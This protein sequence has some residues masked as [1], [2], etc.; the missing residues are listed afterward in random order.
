MQ[1]L[2]EVCVHKPPRTGVYT[3]V[4][5]LVYI[6]PRRFVYTNAPRTITQT[7]KSDYT[8]LEICYTNVQGTFVLSLQG[9]LCTRA[10]DLLHK[11]SRTICVIAPRRFVYKSSRFVTQTFLENVC[12]IATRRFVYKS[13]RFVT[14]TFQGTFV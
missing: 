4:Q 13:S 6:K 8:E 7:S 5:E 11:R 14:Q 1:S 2:L 3:N 10:R 12:V 9:G